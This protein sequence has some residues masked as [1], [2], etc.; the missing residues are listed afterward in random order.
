MNI[1]MGLGLTGI[2]I[3]LLTIIWAIWASVVSDTRK[4]RP[5]HI[6]FTAFLVILTA[7]IFLVAVWLGVIVR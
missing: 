3:G 7:L 4:A 2:I 1:V 6:R 5:W